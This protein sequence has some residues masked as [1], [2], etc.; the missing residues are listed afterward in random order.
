VNRQVERWLVSLI[1]GVMVLAN[2]A[3][4]NSPTPYFWDDPQ[5]LVRQGARFP[6]AV[7]N[8]KTAAAFWQERRQ[9][10]GWPQ[11]F[12]SLTVKNA[13]DSTWTTRRNILGPFTLVGTEA[14]IYSVVLTQSGRFWVAVLGEEGQVILYRSDDGA[15]TF[16]EDQR[17]T[18]TG[19]LLVPKLFLGPGDEPLLMVNQADAFQAN[20]PTFRW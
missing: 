14:Q 16:Q 7:D 20:G 11:S 10:D 5:Y 13:G 19:N 17:L 3:A 15:A 1:L 4:Q 2:L 18:G 6:V 9:T 8:G 12:L